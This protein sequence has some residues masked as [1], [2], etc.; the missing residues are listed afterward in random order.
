M[1]RLPVVDAGGQV[2]ADH[3]IL[4]SLRIVEAP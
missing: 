3:V 2:T 4:G 1:I